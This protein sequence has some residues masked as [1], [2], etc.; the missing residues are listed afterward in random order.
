MESVKSRYIDKRNERVIDF[1]RLIDTIDSNQIR[2]TDFY[3]LTSPGIPKVRKTQSK[4]R[5]TPHDQND[6]NRLRAHIARNC[7]LCG[8]ALVLH[9][10]WYI[11]I[12]QCINYLLHGWS[13]PRISL[14]ASP[15]QAA[16]HTIRNK[17]DLLFSLSRIWKFPDAH[18]TKK[19]SK[20]V[21]INLKPI[22]IHDFMLENS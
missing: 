5:A 12:F 16:K 2:F 19:N 13:R 21:D 18:F 15:Y 11:S 22:I 14:Q 6:W 3:R 10:R 20:A 9:L 4:A 8:V 7:Q 1:F 17:H